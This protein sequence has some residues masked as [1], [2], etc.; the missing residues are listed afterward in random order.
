[1]TEY[2]DMRGIV[3]L[4]GDYVM[5]GKSSRNNPVNLG[6][7]KGVTEAGISVLGDGNSKVGYLSNF[8]ISERVL[9]LPNS[10]T[11]KED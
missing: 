3:I 10:Y 4:V 11:Y 5:Y 8:T 2:K 1:M 6:E 7:V 9:V